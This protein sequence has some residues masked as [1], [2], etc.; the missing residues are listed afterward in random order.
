MDKCGVVGGLRQGVTIRD[1]TVGA[2]TR[3]PCTRK[4]GWAQ[5][6]IRL[7]Q[8]ANLHLFGGQEDDRDRDLLVERNREESSVRRERHLSLG[9]KCSD[10]V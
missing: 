9:H 2:F 3:S 8:R 7:T 5:L 10:W 1:Y 6:K 4:G